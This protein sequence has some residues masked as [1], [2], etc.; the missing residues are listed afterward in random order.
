MAGIIARLLVA[1]LAAF[2]DVLAGNPVSPSEGP[3]YEV[4]GSYQFNIYQW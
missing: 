1:M 4:R 2:R 3:F